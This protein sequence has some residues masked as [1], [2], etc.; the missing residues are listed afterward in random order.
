[1]NPVFLI[2]T[3]ALITFL[4]WAAYQGERALKSHT[5]EIQGNLL[6]NIPE[7]V[8]KLVLL[9]LCAGLAN[10][11]SVSPKDSC[12]TMESCVGLRGPAPVFVQ[13]VIGL[14][15]GIIT[16]FVVNIVSVGAIRIWGRKIYSPEIMKNMVPRNQLEWVLI[17]IPLLV[18]VMVEE[19]LFR[20]LLIGGFQLVV[21]PWVMAIAS[22]VLFGLMHS[23]QG[24]LG[25]VLTGLVGMVFAALFIITSSLLPVIVAH[26]VINF[27]QIIRAEEDLVWYERFE[28]RA[29]QR[30]K[31]NQ[32][33]PTASL[34]NQ[35]A[36]AETLATGNLNN[37]K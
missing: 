25:I 16:V 10:S 9:G 2:G 36:E 8:F 3:L 35:V 27:L 24:I 18:A 12:P 19:F 1:M 34:V 14:I 5:I 21:N 29:R 4:Y 11:L 13:I 20:G 32:P 31:L 26:F 30:A 6:L 7:L 33:P 28:E 23:P 15:A 22:S 37:S 17:I